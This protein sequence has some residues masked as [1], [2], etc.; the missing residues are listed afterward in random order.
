MLAKILVCLDGSETA[1]RVLSFVGKEAA[2]L[3]SKIILLRVVHI[4]QS[5]IPLN[6]PGSPAIPVVTKAELARNI[7]EEKLANDYLEDKAQ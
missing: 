1:E 2:L 3:H 6:I 7:S 4:P 5:N